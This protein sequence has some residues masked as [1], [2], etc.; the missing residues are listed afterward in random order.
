[1]RSIAKEASKAAEH[2]VLFLRKK[3]KSFIKSEPSP[4]DISFP[5]IIY[6]ACARAQ[7]ASQTAKLDS[8]TLW[9]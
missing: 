5:V 3:A 4:L 6:V 9:Y 7:T 8:N 2:D 1:M